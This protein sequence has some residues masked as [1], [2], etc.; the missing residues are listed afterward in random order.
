[1]GLTGL[2]ATALCVAAIGCSGV[3]DAASSGSPTAPGGPPPPAP[4]A[5]TTVT[6]PPPTAPTLIH[7]H[8]PT[9]GRRLTLR[10]DG[11][12]LSW[13]RGAAVTSIGTD[14]FEYRV[15]T[16]GDAPLAFKPLLDDVWSRGPNYTV[17]PHQTTDIYPRFVEAR[18]SV[19][20]PYPAFTSKALPSTR[21]IR[22]YLPPTYRENPLVRM[23]VLYMHDGQNLFS[24]VTAF[25]GNE[26]RIDE[27]MDQGAEDG[28]IRE[29]IVVGID[30]TPE[31]VAEL[32]PT[33]VPGYGG[34]KADAYLEMIEKELAPLVERDL[35]VLP[36]RENRGIAGSSLG[37][38]LSSYAGVRRGSVFGL[39]GSFSPSTWWDGRVILEEVASLPGRPAKPIRVYVD[40][41][42]AGPSADDVVNTKELAASYRSA[43]YKDGVDLLYLVQP[44]AR[45]SEV[46]WA[47]RAP[48]ALGFLLG[49]G[50]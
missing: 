3:G 28:S 46:F 17:R 40:S 20:V 12:G 25:G 31:R 6:E 29:A 19:E 22:V 26:W 42:D 11:A 44:G 13:D 36:G 24:P 2:L 7:V 48:R 32:T 15:V 30:N 39:V 9:K 34:G 43:G 35:R 18:G 4:P 41:G 10:G 1:M 14:S 38:L 27:A 21:K 16:P 8:Y 23:P 5:S 45:H 47:E 49:P 50:R 33:M 37:G